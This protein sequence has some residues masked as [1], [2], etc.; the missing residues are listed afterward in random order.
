MAACQDCRY[1]VSRALCVAPQLVDLAKLVHD[2]PV[3]GTNMEALNM[4]LNQSLCGTPGY[5]FAQNPP[6]PPATVDL[7]ATAP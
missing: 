1:F 2:R 3:P 7:P 5:W 4:R 6:T